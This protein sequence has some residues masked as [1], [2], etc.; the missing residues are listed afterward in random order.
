MDILI[1]APFWCIINPS[2]IITINKFLIWRNIDLTLLSA[3]SFYF[4]NLNQKL[5]HL[6][7]S[8]LLTENTKISFV[9]SLC[10]NLSQRARNKLKNF[11]ESMI[12]IS[13]SNILNFICL[14]DYLKIEL[15]IRSVAKLPSKILRSHRAKKNDSFCQ[16]ETSE[17]FI[18]MSKAS[19]WLLKF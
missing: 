7:S 3:F 12:R 14:I 11:F 2:L 4:W 15:S 6:I 5:L 19:E 10:S 13:L 17:I 8:F 18:L 1:L 9:D 16:E